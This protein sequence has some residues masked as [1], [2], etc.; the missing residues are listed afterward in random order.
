MERTKELKGGRNVPPQ[1]EVTTT[2]NST[3]SSLPNSASSTMTSDENIIESH[4]KG[5]CFHDEKKVA[6]NSKQNKRRRIS[7]QR[8]SLGNSS[9]KSRNPNTPGVFG[10]NINKQQTNKTKMRFLKS[11]EIALIAK[12]L[13]KM[14]LFVLQ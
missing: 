11:I 9:V 1:I 2:D 3:M 6:R 14:M 7:M 12:C 8:E 13:K 10:A 5:V 4:R